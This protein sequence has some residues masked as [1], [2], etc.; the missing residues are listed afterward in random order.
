M[1]FAACA[2]TSSARAQYAPR[3]N[4]YAYDLRLGLFPVAFQ[5]GVS[6]TQFGSALRAEVDLSRRFMLSAAA[7]VPWLVLVGDAG[8]Q[9]FAVRADVAWNFVDRVDSEPLVGTVY[10]DDTPVVSAQ[11]GSDFDV[12]VSQRLG[13]PRFKPPD[14]DRD[15]QASIRSVHALRLGY[16]FVRSVER[17]TQSAPNNLL[18]TGED[19]SDLLYQNTIHAFHLG[20]AWGKHWNLSPASVGKR[21]I[22]W[23][24]FYLDALLTLDPLADSKPLGQARSLPQTKRDFFPVGVRLGMEGSIAALLRRTPGLGF[25]Y[26]LELGA[27]PATSGVDG[28]IFVGLGL[29][30]DVALAPGPATRSASETVL[31][32]AQRPE[33]GRRAAVPGAS[34]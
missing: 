6:Q 3:D 25:G 11:V 1:A 15:H 12:P 9:G 23:R 20:Y 16:D 5:A 30:F 19:A 21:E 32:L 10:A 13:S 17:D 31:R 29:A 33:H 24:R 4:P 2:I 8:S 14:A 7:R 27:L 22:G 34:L 26:S 28:Y 18:P